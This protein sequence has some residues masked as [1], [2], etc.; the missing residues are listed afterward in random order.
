M[1]ID[2]A[3]KRIKENCEADPSLPLVGKSKKCE[4][5]DFFTNCMKA[6]TPYR[7]KI[8]KGDKDI[9]QAIETIQ[10]HCIKYKDNDVCDEDCCFYPNCEKK[11]VPLFWRIIEIDETEEGEW[12][13][14][15]E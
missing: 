11:V 5:C 9:N 3:I 13:F 2:I 8:K 1:D 15:A 10:N 6:I 4:A 14:Y 12:F 7:W